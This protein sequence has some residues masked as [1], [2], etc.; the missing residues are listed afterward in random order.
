MKYVTK[1]VDEETK[2]HKE[3]DQDIISGFMPEIKDSKYCPVSSYI[4]YV[5]ALSPKSEKLWQTPKF[6]EFPTDLATTVYYYGKMGHNKLDSFVADVCKLVGLPKKY[7]NH[8]L[9]VTAI[10]NLTRKNYN[11]KQIM[12]ITGHKSSSSL[13]IYQKVNA[14]EKIAGSLTKEVNNPR[15]RGIISTTNDT[16]ENTE[17][18]EPTKKRKLVDIPD[19]SDPDFNFT[20]E[21]ILQIVEQCE[22]NTEI[23][24]VTNVNNNNNQLTMTSNVVQE[25]SPNIPSFSNCKIGNI[26]INIQK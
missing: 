3:T 20:A 19:E 14:Q 25:R 23:V 7:T 26:T 6:E 10:T 8:T 16:S 12:S 5:N 4:K 2:N 1:A 21:D 22:C 17:N 24:P 18:M 11:N 9:R 15:K 13:E